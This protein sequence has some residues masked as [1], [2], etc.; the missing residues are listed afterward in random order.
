MQTR[1]CYPHYLVQSYLCHF[2][3]KQTELH[4]VVGASALEAHNQ[5]QGILYS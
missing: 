4:D 5:D 1:Q 2:P 3:C